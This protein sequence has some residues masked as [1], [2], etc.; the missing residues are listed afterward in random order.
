MII[1][2]MRT[3]D[4]IQFSYVN[5]TINQF[6]H[7]QHL[8]IFK[9]RTVN[10]RLTLK[11]I[12]KSLKYAKGTLFNVNLRGSLVFTDDLFQYFQGTIHTLDMSGCW[13]ETITDK[14]FSYLQGTIQ[15]L[16]M[17]NC[18]Q[19]TITDEAFSYLKDTICD[20][21]LSGC[22]QTSITDR[23]FLYLTTYGR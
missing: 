6:K 11:E 10:P 2:F 5:R 7:E 12:E 13:R 18:N 8:M 15:I 1:E 19:R 3:E 16:N 9:C 4:W 22:N 20:I 21:D 23:A 17:A 14:A